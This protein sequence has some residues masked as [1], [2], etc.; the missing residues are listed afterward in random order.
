MHYIYIHLK[1]RHEGCERPKEFVNVCCGRIFAEE[2]GDPVIMYPHLRIQLHQM[3]QIA[4]T[5]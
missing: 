4:L 1:V 5:F 3:G 2:L